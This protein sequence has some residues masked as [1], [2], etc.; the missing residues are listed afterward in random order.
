MLRLGLCDR[1]ASV[2]YLSIRVLLVLVY[3]VGA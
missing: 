2:S 3:E 1:V